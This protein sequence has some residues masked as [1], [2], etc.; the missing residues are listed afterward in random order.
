MNDK[1]EDAFQEGPTQDKEHFIEKAV[2]AFRSTLSD[3]EHE[4]HAVFLLYDDNSGKM[5]TYTFNAN[6]ST[7]VM[8]LT[9][10]YELVLESE[11]G[12]K[13]VLN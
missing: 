6:M 7:M 10:A 2:D 1:L 12:I 4:R 5:Q 11:G 3:V 9:T 13:R 8:L